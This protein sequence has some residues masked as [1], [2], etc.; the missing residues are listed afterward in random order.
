MEIKEFNSLMYS[1]ALENWNNALNIINKL[2]KQVDAN[3]LSVLMDME[4]AIVAR[5]NE[6]YTISK[7]FWKKIGKRKNLNDK[8]VYFV[9]A[10]YYDTIAESN[11]DK[12][13][14]KIVERYNLKVKE[15]FE[16]VGDNILISIA[17]ACISKNPEEKAELYK[18]AADELTEAGDAKNAHCATALYYG[19]LADAA[20]KPEEQAEFHKKAADEF[21]EA[22]DAKNA[23][24]STALYYGFLANAVKKPEE[25]AEFHKKAADELTE[26]GDAKNAHIFTAFYYRSLADAAEKPEE[27]AEF[28][29]K[30]AHKFTEASDAKNAH[31]A[32]AFYYRSLA[33]AAEKPEE[34]TEFHKKAADEL[35]EAGDAK[36]AHIATA[37]YYNSLADAAEK[38]EEQAEFY[39]K[40]AD[41]LTEAGDAKSAHR[42]TALYYGFLAI[43]AEKPEEQAEF[44]KKA[45]DEFTEAGDAK[46]AHIFTAFYYNSLA[47]AAEK[48]EEK[49]RL[50]KNAVEE[51]KESGEKELASKLSA[52]YYFFL[53]LSTQ[54]EIESKKYQQLAALET[55]LG[56]LYL[57]QMAF[58][59][60]KKSKAN[61]AVLLEQTIKFYKNYLESKN[62]KFPVSSIYLCGDVTKKSAYRI[63]EDM[64]EYFTFNT[65][66][67]PRGTFKNTQQF[68]EDVTKNDFVLMVLNKGIDN[69]LFYQLGLIAGMGKPIIVLIPEKIKSVD[70]FIPKVA[71][72]TINKKLAFTAF[73]LFSVI[74]SGESLE[75]DDKKEKPI[76]DELLRGIK[77]KPLFIPEFELDKTKLLD[78]SEERL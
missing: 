69:E 19:S 37:F 26:A 78:L 77:E 65:T 48:P 76:I 43:V 28:Y 40:A 35:T 2:K 67:F 22:G 62:E 23:H 30:A 5:K 29:K 33:N 39:K 74:K 61:N 56:W 71:T 53:S 64:S 52:K 27:Q 72:V 75:I 50:Y 17:D 45:T 41:E 44:H 3:L 7:K 16:K 70:T 68:K 18:K 9:K 63:K 14:R 1:T 21:T 51:I 32:T 13:K 8:I 31:I 73:K 10:S 66:L 60:S 42:F 59:E 24:I 12:N 57:T 58:D 20:E 15:C 34:Q 36:N 46:N 47:D 4:H 25:Q 6:D 38:P 11:I 54:N 49:A 55:K